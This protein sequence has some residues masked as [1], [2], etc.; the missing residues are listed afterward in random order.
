[1]FFSVGLTL[2]GVG[3]CVFQIVTEF[4]PA[5]RVAYQGSM[6]A[7]GPQASWKELFPPTLSA[8]IPAV[9]KAQLDKP[10]F[11]SEPLYLD[12]KDSPAVFTWQLPLGGRVVL[13]YAFMLFRTNGNLVWIHMGSNRFKIIHS[14]F[15]STITLP[16]VP[17]KEAGDYY[18]LA[19]VTDLQDQPISLPGILSVVARAT[20]E[21]KYAPAEFV[22]TP[23]FLG[24]FV[25]M[26][27][28]L[29]LLLISRV[30]SSALRT[31]G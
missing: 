2:A 28:G 7:M 10:L 8:G 27:I 16:R 20:P 14:E 19:S 29:T 9:L 6:K 12:P 17:I 5:N 24:G 23:I 30:R 22:W 25:A 13:K 11:Q 26:L 21:K 15:A 1:M 3:V 18:L 31:T 4:W